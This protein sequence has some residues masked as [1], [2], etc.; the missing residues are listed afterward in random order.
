MDKMKNIFSTV[1]CILLLLIICVVVQARTASPKIADFLITN[2]EEKVLL[3]ARL[4][5]GFK[6][7]MKSEIL[8]GVPQDVVLRVKVYEERPWWIWDKKINQSEIKRTIRYDNLIKTFTITTN[9]NPDPAVFPDLSSAQS[10][11]ADFNGVV[12]TSIIALKKGKN[13]YL[14][15]KIIIERFRLPLGMEYIFSFVSYWDYTTDWYKQKFI[16]K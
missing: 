9:G 7:E 6:S 8:A 5:D 13:Y 16:L 15:V 3:Y 4:V 11:M 14:K 2:D 10:A 1:L 12:V